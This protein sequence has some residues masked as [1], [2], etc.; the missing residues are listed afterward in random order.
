MAEANPIIP[1]FPAQPLPIDELGHRTLADVWPLWWKEK[2][3]YISQ[4]T[5]QCYRDYYRALAPFFGMLR[6]SDISIEL[7]VEYRTERLVTAGAGLVNH[8]INA[9]GQVL[10]KAGLWVPIKRHYK[11][12]PVRKRGSI[13][14]RIGQEELVHLFT[15]A[16]SNPR[17]RLAYLCS[18]VCAS[19][20]CGPSEILNLRL[21]NIKWEERMLHVI[22][23]TKTNDRVRIIDMNE[24]C[25]FA[26]REL[27]LIAKQKG[28]CKPEHYLLPHR[29]DKEGDPPDPTRH[30]L[31]YRKAWAGLRREASKKYPHLANVRRYD[32]RH[33][34]ISMLCENPAMDI[35]TIHQIVGHAPGSKLVTDVYFHATRK[36][37]KAAVQTLQGI[38]RPT[39]QSEQHPQAATVAVG[40]SQWSSSTLFGP[41][42]QVSVA[43]PIATTTHTKL[44]LVKG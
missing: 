1:A 19:T 30:M 37:K 34:S 9:L 5:Q 16:Q 25:F 4:T 8:E 39:I 6:L 12:L 28:S 44:R 13:G 10:D 35:Q 21:G 32:L 36:R 17:W 2:Q 41:S 31:S 38:T 27:E 23:G 43:E 26:L 24:D 22:E 29:A 11:Q 40:P 18:M 20:T 33:T 15:C 3:Q 42:I 7:L 14:Q